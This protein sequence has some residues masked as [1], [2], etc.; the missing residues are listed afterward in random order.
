MLCGLFQQTGTIPPNL[1]LVFRQFT[2]G[3]DNLKRD[4][5]AREESRR[6][7]EM[8]LQRLAFV[9]MQGDDPQNRPTE[10]RVAISK[11]EAQQIFEAALQPKVADPGDRALE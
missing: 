7:W 1:G 10:F 3:Y 4:V 11:A 2:R 8:L 9:M 6:W 5:P